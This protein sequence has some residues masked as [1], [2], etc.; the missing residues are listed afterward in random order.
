MKLRCGTRAQLSQTGQT[1]MR[2]DT[3]YLVYIDSEGENHYQPWRDV[4]YVGTLID[5]DGEDMKLVG[6]ATEIPAA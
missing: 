1:S 3:M 4:P 5:D 6:W 2:T